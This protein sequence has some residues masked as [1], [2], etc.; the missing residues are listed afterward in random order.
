MWAGRE[1]ESQ[2]QG[3]H[4]AGEQTLAVGHV[5]GQNSTEKSRG[6]GGWYKFNRNTITQQP[7]SLNCSNNS[8]ISKSIQIRCMRSEG[9][10]TESNCFKENPLWSL[11]AAR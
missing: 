5:L 2:P 9:K 11:W 8:I 4:H 1:T 7:W 10:L 6:H 3:G